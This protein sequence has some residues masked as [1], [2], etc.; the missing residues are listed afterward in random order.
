[1]SKETSLLSD[2]G[3]FYESIPFEYLLIGHCLLVASWFPKLKDRYILSYWVSSLPL[4]RVHGPK[5]TCAQ[6]LVEG[7]C[8]SKASPIALQESVSNH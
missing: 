2:L 6:T 3:S 8:T 1:M 5:A 7:A 4:E